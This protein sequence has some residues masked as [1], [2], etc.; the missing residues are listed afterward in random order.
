M[1]IE[2]T[3]N[4]CEIKTSYKLKLVVLKEFDG[5]I[6]GCS[7]WGLSCIAAHIFCRDLQEM[8]TEFWWWKFL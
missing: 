1:K 6:T 4:R 5:V 3:A 2:V 7:L 8:C